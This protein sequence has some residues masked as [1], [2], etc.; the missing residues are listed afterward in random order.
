MGTEP[1]N[2][3]QS[4]GMR[5]VAMELRNIAFAQQLSAAVELEDYMNTG[6]KAAQHVAAALVRSADRIMALVKRCEGEK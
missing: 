2:I 3:A 6:S 1:D 4:F 5:E